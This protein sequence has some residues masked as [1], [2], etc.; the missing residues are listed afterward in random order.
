M[1]QLASDKVIEQE[2][3]SQQP[4]GHQYG[5]EQE[6][7]HSFAAILYTRQKAEIEYKRKTYSIGK[8]I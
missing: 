1:P 4:K 3:K 2:R 5:E 7:A 8:V 6:H